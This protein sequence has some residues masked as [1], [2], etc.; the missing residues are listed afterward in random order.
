MNPAEKAKLKVSLEELSI[1]YAKLDLI[2]EA[3]KD[4]ID[5]LSEEYDI[6]TRNL[7]KIAL[8]MHKRNAKEEFEKNNELEELYEEIAGVEE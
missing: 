4:V 3:I 5:A 8:M 1:E 7:R 6:S 2:R